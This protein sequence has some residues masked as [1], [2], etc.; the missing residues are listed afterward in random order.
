MI[1]ALAL[2]PVEALHIDGHSDELVQAYLHLWLDGVV[3]DEVIVDRFGESTLPLFRLRRRPAAGERP[4]TMVEWMLFNSSY[5]GG[6]TDEQIVAEYGL[7]TLERFQD[8]RA[9][10]GGLTPPQKGVAPSK[11]PLSWACG[12]GN[13]ENAGP[14]VMQKLARR[15]GPLTTWTTWKTGLLPFLEK[16]WLLAMGLGT[17]LRLLLE[18]VVMETWPWTMVRRIHAGGGH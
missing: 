1:E 11:R 3:P 5:Q 7:E 2:A 4:L 6:L 13:R 14:M 17:W 12:H 9:L 16:A 10:Q 15:R 18:L 8:E